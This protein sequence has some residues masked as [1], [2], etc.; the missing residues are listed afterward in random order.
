MKKANHA[1]HELGFTTIIRRKTKK[2][3]RSAQLKMLYHGECTRKQDSNNMTQLMETKEQAEDF[4][5]EV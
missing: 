1:D 5:K 4:T 3:K 2:K